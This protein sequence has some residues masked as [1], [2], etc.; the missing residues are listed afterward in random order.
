MKQFRTWC[1]VAVVGLLVGTA[2]A[3]EPPKYDVLKAM[4]DDAKAKLAAAQESKNDLANK[5]EGLNKQIA[6][7]QKQ[8][9]AVTRERDELQR[10][11]A[12][13]AEKTYN[14]RSYYAAWQEFVKRYPSLQVKWKV[15]LETEL[16]KTGNEAPSLVEPSWPFRIEG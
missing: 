9:D 2:L 14:L 15:F 13:Y 1:A 16:L 10:Q 8:L 11:A 12:T 7:L 4:Y 3:Q 6:E 5:N